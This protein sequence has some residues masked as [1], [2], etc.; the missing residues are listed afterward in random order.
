[1]VELAAV[2]AAAL[3]ELTQVP[4]A[5]RRKQPGARLQRCCPRPHP[6]RLGD[7]CYGALNLPEL[8]LC[9]RVQRRHR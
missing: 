4:I 5:S 8:V 9:G 1:V 2:H 6:Q 7:D 3:L